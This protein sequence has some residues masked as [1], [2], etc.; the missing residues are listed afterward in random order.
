MRQALVYLLIMLLLIGVF[1]WKLTQGP[2]GVAPPPGTPSLQFELKVRE[3]CTCPHACAQIRIL[4]AALAPHRTAPH[5][6]HLSLHPAR[7]CT[8]CS[9]R[10]P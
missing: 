2:K 8:R 1:V 3:R 4:T 7:R 6:T 9:S 10:A 5:R